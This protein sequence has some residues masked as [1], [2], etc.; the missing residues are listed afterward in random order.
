MYNLNLKYLIFCLLI[1]MLIY[2]T[3]RV[4]TTFFYKESYLNCVQLC[5]FNNKG[6]NEL[7]TT[8]K[9][10]FSKVNFQ[11]NLEYLMFHVLYLGK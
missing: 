9:V 10:I 5:L 4:S 6:C 11:T 2:I 1:I 3:V 7:I 8:S